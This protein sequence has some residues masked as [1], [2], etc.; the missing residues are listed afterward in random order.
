MKKKKHQISRLFWTSVI[1]GLV[2]LSTG[3]SFVISFNINNLSG[4]TITINYSLKDL[5]H[6]GLSPRLVGENSD[7]KKTK[8]IPIPED[9][10]RVDIENRI[11]DLKLLPNENVELFSVIDRLDNDYEEEFS[12]SN[13]RI[14]GTDG[15]VSLEGR[16]VFK[17]FRPIKKNWYAFGPEI[18][19]FVLEHR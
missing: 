6:G 17:S 11:V 1:I 5:Q 12:L 9:R 3:C 16:Q 4:Q 18:T 14:T 2:M 8:F 19:G 15:S 7:D 13:L 10:L